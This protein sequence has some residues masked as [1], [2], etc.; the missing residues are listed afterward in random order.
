MMLRR[1]MLCRMTIFMIALGRILKIDTYR[2]MLRGMILNR[3]TLK[4]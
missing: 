1:I 3:M 4:E 2:M